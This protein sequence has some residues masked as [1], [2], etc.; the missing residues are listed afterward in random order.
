MR[1]IDQWFP[2]RKL[3]IHL[4]DNRTDASQLYWNDGK[5]HL[6]MTCLPVFGYQHSTPR[7]VKTI[8]TELFTVLL[9]RRYEIRIGTYIYV[10]P[11]RAIYIADTERLTVTICIIW[12]DLISPSALLYLRFTSR[13]E[14]KILHA[15]KE[16][17]EKRNN[18]RY[19]PLF[20]LAYLYVYRGSP[21]SLTDFTE[22]SGNVAAKWIN[23]FAALLAAHYLAEVAGGGK[24]EV[25]KLHLQIMSRSHLKHSAY[26]AT[27]RVVLHWSTSNY[28]SVLHYAVILGIMSPLCSALRNFSLSFFLSLG[29][30]SSHVRT[31]NKKSQQRNGFTGRKKNY[32]PRNVTKYA[33]YVALWGS[34]LFRNT[35]FEKKYSR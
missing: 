22:K 13:V 4:I 15:T 8:S 3:T 9:M 24:R 21:I 34:R 6:A 26:N 5:Q 2:A 29:R 14:F 7:G 31:G 28:T 33:M 16:R 1:I 19:N 27:A 18:G 30:F 11:N 23:G 20:Y 17:R 12:G 35:Y 10:H 32:S 25:I